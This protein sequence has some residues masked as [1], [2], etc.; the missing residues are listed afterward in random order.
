MHGIKPNGCGIVSTRLRRA[1]TVKT[2][3]LTPILLFLA[4]CGTHPVKMYDGPDRPSTEVSTVRLWS[5]GVMV[6]K[7]DGKCPVIEITC[8]DFAFRIKEF[9]H[10]VTNSPCPLDI[11][12]FDP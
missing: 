10:T 11:L 9:P 12:K 2:W 7:I 6:L 1:A 8:D 5:P 4:A 3:A